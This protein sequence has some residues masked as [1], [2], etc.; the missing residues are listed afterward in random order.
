MR[1]RQCG[2]LSCGGLQAKHC[3]RGMLPRASSRGLHADSTERIGRLTMLMYGGDRLP[4]A[5]THGCT[6]THASTNGL[7]RPSP[8]TVKLMGRDVKLGEAHL[9]IQAAGRAHNEVCI[10]GKRTAQRTA[11]DRVVRKQTLIIVC[12]IVC[13]LHGACRGVEFGEGTLLHDHALM[14]D[15]SR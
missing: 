1:H 4:A 12:S 13:S 7:R 9:P 10:L 15:A 14:R 6:A 5:A 11:R 8:R 2:R 3:A